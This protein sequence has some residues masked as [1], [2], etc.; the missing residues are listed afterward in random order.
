MDVEIYQ[1]SLEEKTIIQNLMQLYLYDFSQIDGGDVDNFGLFVF[2]YLYKY[3]AEAGRYPFLVQV[4][5]KLA[6]FS[7]L[8][9]G[10]YFEYRPDQE[11]KGMIVAE[12]FVMRKFRKRGVGKWMAFQ[13]F[14]RFPV[15]WEIA[16]TLN[17]TAAQAFWRKVIKQYTGGSFYEH[18]LDN[19]NW[20]GP[21]KV[22]NN[23]QPENG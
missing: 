17:N 13:L 2:P 11:G 9:S 22:F 3:W 15:R 18:M 5:G 12:F 7:L 23:S 8:R 20:R 1:A 14:N 21:V 6:G 4:D 10:T 16:Q 19:E